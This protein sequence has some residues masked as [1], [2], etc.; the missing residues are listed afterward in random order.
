MRRKKTTI[1]L[2]SM[3]KSMKKERLDLVDRDVFPPV[4]QMRELYHVSEIET[5]I[6]Y[7][8]RTWKDK[9]FWRKAR[10]APDSK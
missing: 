6:V 4:H 9:L 2:P 8:R 5:E 7:Q 1:F 3:S 10:I